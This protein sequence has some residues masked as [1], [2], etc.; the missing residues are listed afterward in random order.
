[1]TKAYLKCAMVLGAMALSAVALGGCET[2]FDLVGVATPLSAGAAHRFDGS[3]QGKINLV[4]HTGLGCPASEGE[5]VVMI[6][7]GV[8]WYAYSPSTLFALPVGYDGSI[9]GRAGDTAMV[10][11]IDGNHMTASIKSATCQAR[12]SMDYIYNHS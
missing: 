4:S 10:G 11:K 7:D 1:M 3:Y 5:R 12:M 6:G 2:T 8:L 9:D